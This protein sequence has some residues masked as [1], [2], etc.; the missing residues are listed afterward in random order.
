MRAKNF[1]Y[2]IVIVGIAI[3]FF[4]ISPFDESKNPNVI[5]HATLA[6]P[7]LYNNGEF[8]DSFDAKAGFYEFQFI[9]NGDSPQTLSIRIDGDAYHFKDDFELEGTLHQTGISEYY[10][11]DYLGDKTLEVPKNM[12]LQIRINPNGN[13]NGP[14]SIQL[15]EN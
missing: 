8:T 1:G 7:T 15:L 6:D 3:A 9:P 4:V 12:T 14:V 10:T 5:F 2:I 11:W 13:L